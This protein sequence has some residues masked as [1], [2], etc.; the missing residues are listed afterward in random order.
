MRVVMPGPSPAAVPA[1]MPAVVVAGRDA[2]GD[3]IAG[4]RR[5]LPHVVQGVQDA[6]IDA[7][8]L[9]LQRPG[10]GQHRGAVPA[11]VIGNCRCNR[12]ATGCDLRCYGRARI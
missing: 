4:Q 12:S 8:G 3:V 2:A 11:E 7:G 1:S 10:H 9:Q 5:D 6:A